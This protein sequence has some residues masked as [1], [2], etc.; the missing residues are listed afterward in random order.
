MTTVGLLNA[1]F[2]RSTADPPADEWYPAGSGVLETEDGYSVRFV[3]AGQYAVVDVTVYPYHNQDE[4]P[5]VGAEVLY[6]FDDPKVLT[7]RYG[8]IATGFGS[9]EEARQYAETSAVALGVGSQWEITFYDGS[10]DILGN[11]DFGG[12]PGDRFV[13]GA[14]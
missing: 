5:S 4:G 6:I 3:L 8:D 11:F 12:T 10:T 9:A 14:C 1:L 2:G 13:M 7:S